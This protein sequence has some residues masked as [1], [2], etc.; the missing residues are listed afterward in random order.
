MNS[1]D[2]NKGFVGRLLRLESTTLYVVCRRP[3]SVTR[4]AT[5]VRE[6]V[7][8]DY[9]RCCLRLLTL[10]VNDEKEFVLGSRL[11]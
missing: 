11:P 5:D 8:P 4:V 3:K 2:D 10:L 7:A 1:A 9:Q 6:I